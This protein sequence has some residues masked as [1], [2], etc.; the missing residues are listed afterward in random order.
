[1][2]RQ[3]KAWTGPTT[4]RVMKEGARQKKGGEPQCEPPDGLAETI[5]AAQPFLNPRKKCHGHQ[6]GGLASRG[7]VKSGVYKQLWPTRREEGKRA[8]R[9]RG[10]GARP[11]FLLAS[12]VVDNRYVSTSP[13][14][15]WWL[16]PATGL[17]KPG[18]KGPRHGRQRVQ[19][20]DLS[21]C[22]C[23]WR[24]PEREMECWREHDNARSP[25]VV[26]SGAH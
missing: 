4:T 15:M 3:G 13:C 2:T 23:W 17:G 20:H 14:P 9:R 11:G 19:S 7:S 22:C 5:T 18:P 8:K 6:R 10:P 25:Y 26:R 24:R 1:M 16:V 12:R 21:W